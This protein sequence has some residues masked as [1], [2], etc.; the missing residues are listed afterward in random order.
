MDISG[1]DIKD[2]TFDW[3]TLLADQLDWHW[4]AHLRPRLA[5]LTDE[6]YFW[7]PVAD[8]WNV[9]R[10]GTSPAPMAVGA[11]EFTIDFAMPE[12]DPAPVTTISWRIA[13]LLVGIFGDRNARHFGGAPTDYLGYDYP[14]TAA[15]ALD[16]LDAAYARWIAGVRDLRDDDLA[17]ACG[18]EPQFTD[19]PM[20]ELVLHI[21]RETIHHGAELCLLRDLYAH[22]PL[23]A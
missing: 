9:R 8:C 22:R 12:P 2:T 15:A 21:G 4:G 17:A 13:H 18:E 7:E 10:R 3:T 1:T 20:A 19:R 14:G 6:E 5:G 23:T 11:G 16:L